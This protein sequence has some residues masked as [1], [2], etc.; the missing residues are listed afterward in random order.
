LSFATEGSTSTQRFPLE[1]TWT[2]CPPV[3][4]ERIS[5]G[6]SETNFRSAPSA[7]QGVQIRLALMGRT[8]WSAA[9]ALVGLVASRRNSIPWATAGPGGPARTRGSAPLCSC[10]RP[11]SCQ[12][13][14]AQLADNTRVCRVDTHV[15]AFRSA[16]LL[17]PVGVP[18]TPPKGRSCRSS[19]CGLPSR[20]RYT[21]SRGSIEGLR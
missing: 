11:F 1:L 13:M 2:S 5:T 19:R 10:S 6:T 4:K 18:I 8:P 7:G 15:D 9:D 3:P 14:P 20:G 12:S 17:E 16:T 21:H